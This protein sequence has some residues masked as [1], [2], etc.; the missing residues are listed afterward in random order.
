LLSLPGSRLLGLPSLPTLPILPTLLGLL[1]LLALLAFL[2]FSAPAAAAAD[3]PIGKIVK[4]VGQIWVRSQ[5][6]PPTGEWVLVKD[7]DHPLYAGDDIRSGRGRAEILFRRD[8]GILRVLENTQLTLR[9]APEPN[10]QVT[11]RRIFLVL[12]RVWAQIAPRRGLATQFESNAAIAGLRGTTIEYWV[13]ANGDTW[14]LCTEGSVEVT[15]A[16]V[17]ITLAV[18]Q[19]TRVTPGQPPLAPFSLPAAPPPTVEE[20]VVLEEKV[21]TPPGVP[22]VT[23]APTPLSPVTGGGGIV[24]PSR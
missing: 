24:S 1:S 22:A 5:V 19:A 4:F 6:H 20:L 23:V 16:G 11:L 3:E 12:G 17:T 7:K 10:R 21:I 9:E 15:A 8:E 18:G 14:V 13:D 2:A